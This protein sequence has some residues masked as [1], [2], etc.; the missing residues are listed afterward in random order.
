[1][2]QQVRQLQDTVWDYYRH[3]KR[4]MPWRDNPTPYYVLVSELMLQQ[5]QVSRVMEKFPPFIKV[6]PDFE[7][8]AAATPAQVIEHW[9]GLG[10]NRRALFLH[11]AAQAVVERFSGRLPSTPEELITLPGVG[12]GTAGSLAAF[13]YNEPTVFIETNIRRV[14][15]H[16]CFTDREGVS[17]AELLPYV[18]AAVDKEH[19]R[20]WYYA[21]MDYGTH[22]AKQVPNPNRRSKHHAVQSKFKGSDRQVRGAVL[23]LLV[24]GA[25]VKCTLLPSLLGEPA[26]RVEK[27]VAGLQKE[28]FVRI[29]GEELRLAE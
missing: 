27:I 15:L 10:Y 12:P 20:E 3:N 13:T 21:L 23:R 5:T 2:D 8:L 22:L 16:H 1:M 19:P 17:D 9:Q 11:R 4:D 28:G 6:F 24:G 18:A 14:F 26:E 7:T 25:T 29:I